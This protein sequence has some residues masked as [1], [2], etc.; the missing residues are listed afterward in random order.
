MVYRMA[1]EGGDWRIDVA[2]LVE[3]SEVQ[4]PIDV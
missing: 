4:T 1:N 3:P 2:G